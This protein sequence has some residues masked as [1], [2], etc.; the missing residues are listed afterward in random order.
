MSLRSGSP[1]GGFALNS[2]NGQAFASAS[3]VFLHRHTRSDI[4]TLVTTRLNSNPNYQKLLVSLPLRAESDQLQEAILDGAEGLFLWVD[5]VLKCI[6]DEIASPTSFETL[7]EIVETAPRELDEFFTR[8]LDDIPK[9]HRRQAWLVF[10]MVL[11]TLGY[12]LTHRLNPTLFESV[13]KNAHLSAFGLSYIL[14]LSTLGCATLTQKQ[15]EIPVS[16]LYAGETYRSREEEASTKLKSQCKGLVE[17]KRGSVTISDAGAHFGYL[18][19]S[20]RSIPE[21]LREKMQQFAGSLT[22]TEGDITYGILASSLAELK[23]LHWPGSPSDAAVTFRVKNTLA[24][25]SMSSPELSVQA[26]LLLDDIATTLPLMA[27]RVSDF[28]FILDQ[29]VS[30]MRNQPFAHYSR[31]ITLLLMAIASEPPLTKPQDPTTTHES[32]WRGLLQKYLVIAIRSVKGQAHFWIWDELE[33][34][35]R[36]GAE[37][38]TEILVTWS[39]WSEIDQPTNTVVRFRFR[40]EDAYAKVIEE[41]DRFRLNGGYAS[42]GTLRYLQNFKSTTLSSII[43]WHDPPN[44]STLLQFTD[45]ESSRAK[46]VHEWRPPAPFPGGFRRWHD[47]P[48]NFPNLFSDLLECGTWRSVRRLFDTG[49]IESRPLYGLYW[50]DD[51]KEW[52]YPDL[53]KGILIQTK[54]G[55]DVDEDDNSE[56]TTTKENCEINKKKPLESDENPKQEAEE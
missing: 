22:V 3:R 12:C 42:D 53:D 20:H 30:T 54:G 23:A 47:M 56:A 35:L 7:R 13:A 5:L 49:M 17:V 37:V 18:A 19:F 6:E 38:P 36:Y 24:L 48:E 26:L 33:F 2:I 45:L 39:D 27:S 43:R 31:K 21:L 4:R 28:D 11:R 16:P 25:T 50:R 14:D 41:D 9:H 52:W 44:A 29:Q 8:I 1:F 40:G 55:P 34:W 15:F 46:G 10:A 32:P 51:I